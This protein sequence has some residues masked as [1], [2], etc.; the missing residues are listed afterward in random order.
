[1]TTIPQQELALS[2]S[3]YPASRAW[4][5]ALEMTAKIDGAPERIFPAVIEELGLRFGNAPALFSRG[6]N[7]SHADL[8]ARANRYARW[9]LSQNIAKGDAICLLFG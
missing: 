8:A 7:W 5:G 6:E 2:A 3:S 4:L 1:M 9:A